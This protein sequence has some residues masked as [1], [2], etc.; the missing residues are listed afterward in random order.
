MYSFIWSSLV[1]SLNVFL[2]LADEKTSG[3]LILWSSRSTLPSLTTKMHNEVHQT[4]SMTAKDA[5]QYL[6][7]ISQNFE[8]I[9]F[10]KSS[11]GVEEVLKSPSIA[12]S[13]KS[14]NQKRILYS[15]YSTIDHNVETSISSSLV[16]S[17]ILNV[18]K[19]AVPLTDD[20]A[21]NIKRNNLLHNSQLDVIEVNIDNNAEE[22]LRKLLDN[23][24]TEDG[25]VL[26]VT[27][28]EP[29]SNFQKPVIDGEYARILA[30]TSS[31]QGIYYK[32][33]GAEYAIYYAD[34]YLYLTPDIFTGI[35]TGIFTFFVAL[36]GL[37]CLGSIQGMS[38]F[39]DKLPAVGREN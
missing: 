2:T 22:A 12:D 26:F 39:Y 6:E 9:V 3:R 16:S 28:T 36:I 27:Y 24:S 20:L 37:R 19:I 5:T 7:S 11:T 1:L 14:T 10:L 30:T 38:S 23:I 34:T 17:K 8:V 25:K 35:M 13:I 33:E 18:N 21:Q 4:R 32:P 29:S 15:I 31:D